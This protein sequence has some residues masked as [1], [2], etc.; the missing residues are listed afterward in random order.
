MLAISKYGEHP[1]AVDFYIMS[2]ANI[3]TA[4]QSAHTT[5]VPGR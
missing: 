5:H 1:R 3:I 2:S 4:L